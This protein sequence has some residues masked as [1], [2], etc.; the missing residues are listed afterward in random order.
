MIILNSLVCLLMLMFALFQYNDP[1]PWLWATIYAVPALWAGLTAAV[2]AL[3]RRKGARLLLGLC[4][5]L[6]L[7]G[8]GFYWPDVPGFWKPTIWWH[9]DL[10]MTTSQAELAREAMGMMIALAA[11]V[12]TYLSHRRR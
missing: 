8:V 5:A 1:D 7:V 2:P 4:I 3:T 6:S 9:G 12:I 11:L 10:A